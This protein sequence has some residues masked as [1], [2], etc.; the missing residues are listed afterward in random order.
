VIQVTDHIIA[1]FDGASILKG[2][3]CGAGGVFKFSAQKVCRW[4]INGGS[5][6]NSKAELLGAWVTLIL[7]KLWNIKS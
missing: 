3:N 1:F 6:T 2:L 7:A 5:G 4:H